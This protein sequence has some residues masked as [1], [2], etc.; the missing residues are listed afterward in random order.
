[1]IALL[2]VLNTQTKLWF[3]TN[4]VSIKRPKMAE[5][6]GTMYRWNE[7]LSSIWVAL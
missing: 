5:T 7:H 6:K 4:T 1:M 3:F 2:L